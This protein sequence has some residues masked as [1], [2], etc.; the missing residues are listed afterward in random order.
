MTTMVVC[1]ACDTVLGTARDLDAV[2][3]L[4]WEHVDLCLPSRRIVRDVLRRPR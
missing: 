4:M 2:E 1:P 3:T